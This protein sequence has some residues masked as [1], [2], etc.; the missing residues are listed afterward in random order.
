MVVAVRKGV[1][2]IKAGLLSRSSYLAKRELC[3]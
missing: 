2:L 3:I 1:K